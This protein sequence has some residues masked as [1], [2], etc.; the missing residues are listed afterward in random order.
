MKSSYVN[1]IL[2]RWHRPNINKLL[3][4]TL[5]VFFLGLLTISVPASRLAPTQ[6]TL[7]LVPSSTKLR[8]GNCRSQR[9]SFF[10]S[11]APLIDEVNNAI[12]RD[13]SELIHIEQDFLNG[14]GLSS[15]NRRFLD[16]LATRYRMSK[17]DIVNCDELKKRVDVIPRALALAQAANETGYGTSRFAREAH[18]YFGQWCFQPG[19]GVVPAQ[20]RP[21]ALHEVKKFNGPLESVKAYIH[22]LN[23]H[24]AYEKLR[25]LRSQYRLSK[26]EF[27]ALDLVAGLE[28]YS[29][30][31]MD[32]ISAISALIRSTGG[33]EQEKRDTRA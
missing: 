22:L 7:A 31:G 16:E 30:R 13:R 26:G 28:K 9:A 32:Y 25:T 24:A 18:N 27:S 12:L 14:K 21:G 3:F 1:Y 17:I 15:K 33:Y 10:R 11:M 20:R 4:L 2:C 6:E 29:E 23:T 8:E 5:A 19:C